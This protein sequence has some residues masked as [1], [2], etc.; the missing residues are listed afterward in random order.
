GGVVTNSLGL[1]HTTW[2]GA[3]MVAGAVLLTGWS[4]SLER[5]DQKSGRNIS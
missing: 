3:L 5:K 2:V 4:R 1:V